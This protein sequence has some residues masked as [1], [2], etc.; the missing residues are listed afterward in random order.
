VR[1]TVRKTVRK[2]VR[3]PVRKT[4]LKIKQNGVKLS[5]DLQSKFT[6][7]IVHTKTVEILFIIC[8]T[9]TF[10]ICKKLAHCNKI[11]KLHQKLQS[12]EKKNSHCNANS[13]Y[14]L[15]FIANQKHS[16]LCTVT[17]KIN[18]FLHL[19]FKFCE[20]SKAISLSLPPSVSAYKQ[21]GCALLT[22]IHQKLILQCELE[23]THC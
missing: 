1:K 5:L 12:C 20:N 7:C 16:A 21:H 19:N 17:S 13:H 14:Y 22:K 23:L 8:C 11:W 15:T 10:K 6:K 4:M 3:K 9:F 18:F 2:P